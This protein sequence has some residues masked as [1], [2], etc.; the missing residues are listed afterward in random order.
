MSSQKH[1]DAKTL[2]L[3]D[4]KA[5]FWDNM[6]TQRHNSTK[7]NAQKHIVQRHDETRHDAIKPLPL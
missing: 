5:Q 3:K 2:K 4:S 1:D 6:I 7:S